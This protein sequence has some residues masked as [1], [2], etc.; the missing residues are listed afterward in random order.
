MVT[1]SRSLYQPPNL[2]PC[3][4]VKKY[5]GNVCVQCVQYLP[6]NNSQPEEIT[7]VNG[8]TA[9]HPKLLLIFLPCSDKIVLCI[10]IYTY[11][12]VSTIYLFTCTV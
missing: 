4:T 12:V 10:F 2:Q 3:K 5:F 1:V 6:V 11:S 7:L 8:G 9:G